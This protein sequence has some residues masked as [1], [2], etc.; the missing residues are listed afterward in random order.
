MIKKFFLYSFIL[1]VVMFFVACSNPKVETAVEEKKVEESVTSFELQSTQFRS[2]VFN[3]EKAPDCIL[4]AYNNYLFQ[5]KVVA[6]FGAIVHS[7]E[8]AALILKEASARNISPAIVFALSWEESRFNQ[9]AVNR[10]TNNSIDR[11]LFQLNSS[12]FP[13][14][15][16][17]DFFDPET[18]TRNAMAHLRWCL[19]SAKSDVAG[20]A[21]YNA[22]LNRVKNGGTPKRTLD[23]VARILG[24]SANIEELFLNEMNIWIAEME[25]AEEARI[26]A[27]ALAEEP[28]PINLVPID[29]LARVWAGFLSTSP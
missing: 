27:E 14:L 29:S 6:F 10:N 8:L 25:A 22:G 19:D 24:H 23:Y 1:L 3:A 16:E 5:D 9:K 7:N 28:N 12:S 2:L 17:A 21:M 18:N 26:L 20:L 13:K 15:K 11:G 4:E